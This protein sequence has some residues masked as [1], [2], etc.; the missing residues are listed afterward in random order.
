MMGVGVRR[1]GAGGAEN[2]LDTRTR[3]RQSKKLNAWGMKEMM[4]IARNI[5][6]KV[7]EEKSRINGES[8]YQ[9]DVD[10]QAP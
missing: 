3:G 8:R 4:K 9:V 1:G 6:V 2:A 5:R 7:V 10:Y